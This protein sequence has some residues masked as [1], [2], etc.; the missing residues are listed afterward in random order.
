MNGDVSPRSWKCKPLHRSARSRDFDGSRRYRFMRTKFHSARNS[1][2]FTRRPCKD[3]QQASLDPNPAHDQLS[4]A[5]QLRPAAGATCGAVA[6][7]CARP[8]SGS[9]GL[10]DAASPAPDFFSGGAEDRQ[11]ING[12][13][14]PHPAPVWKVQRGCLFLRAIPDR[15]A[16]SRNQV[17]GRARP[18]YE[19]E[20]WRCMRG[21]YAATARDERHS[22]A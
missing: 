12:A 2:L 4:R 16:K 17:N 9:S 11:A 13:I 15:P 14:C 7:N 19:G 22:H 20:P 6:G 3:Q 21:R 1:Q 8:D 18:E 10:V 5:A